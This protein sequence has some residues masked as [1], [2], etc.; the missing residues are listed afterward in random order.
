M[1]C[2]ATWAKCGSSVASC[3]AQTA[4][5]SAGPPASARIEIAHRRAV[6]APQEGVPRIQPL[7]GTMTDAPPR[8]VAALQIALTYLYYTSG[9][10]RSLARRER[11]DGC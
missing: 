2:R 10:S 9:R 8:R 7:L 6:G 5:S 3:G 11:H 4:T 1:I